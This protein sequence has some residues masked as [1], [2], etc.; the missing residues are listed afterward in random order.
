MSPNELAVWKAG[1]LEAL[2]EYPVIRYACERVGIRREQYH[3]LQDHDPDFARACRLAMED[4][5]DRLELALFERALRDDTAAG[6]FLLKHRRPEIFS[7]RRWTD[8]AARTL[9]ASFDEPLYLRESA[10][11]VE[12]DDVVVT[13]LVRAE[14]ARAHG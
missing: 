5:I 11:I 13:D 4:G 6:I 14:E 9:P 2:R 12:A 3:W 7:E 8:G 10:E 1:I